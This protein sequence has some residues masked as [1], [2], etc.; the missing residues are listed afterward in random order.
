MLS[1]FLLIDILANS[2][3]C[4]IDTRCLDL[5]QTFLERIHGSVHVIWQ[6]AD[7]CKMI[8]AIDF[9]I[10]IKVFNTSIE[11]PVNQIDFVN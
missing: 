3:H 5:Q 8:Y 9:V 7:F 2:F 11:H 4:V 10:G 1:P 6:I